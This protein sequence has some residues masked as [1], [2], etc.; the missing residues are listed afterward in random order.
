MQAILEN[1][2]LLHFVFLY[3]GSIWNSSMETMLSKQLD[4]IIFEYRYVQ[5]PWIVGTI[6]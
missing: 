5:F 6:N 3:L 2:T 1:K 4:L